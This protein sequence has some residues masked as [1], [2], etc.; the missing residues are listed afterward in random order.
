MYVFSISVYYENILLIG[1]MHIFIRS[2]PGRTI[3]IGVNDRDT[4]EYLKTNIQARLNLHIDRQGL[5]YF[6][7]ILSNCQTLYECGIERDATLHV[8]AWHIESA[9]Q[10]NGIIVT[11]FI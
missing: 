2:Q 8:T 10:Y 1:D 11:V 7:Q 4:V 3:T 6:S 5:R 9:G